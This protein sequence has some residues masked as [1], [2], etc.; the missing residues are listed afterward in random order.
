MAFDFTGAPYLYADLYFKPFSF[1]CGVKIG[2]PEQSDSTMSVS[3]RFYMLDD[4]TWMVVGE[5]GFDK[6]IYRNGSIEAFSKVY[7]DGVV[8]FLPLENGQVNPKSNVSFADG[9]RFKGAYH[10]EKLMTSGRYNGSENIK[11]LWNSKRLSDLKL[12]MIAGEHTTPRGITEQWKSGLPGDYKEYLDNKNAE[13]E[14][15]KYNKFFE[16]MAVAKEAAK[17]QL[18]EEGFDKNDVLTLLDKGEIRIGMPM[19]LIQRANDLKANLVIENDYTVD[20]WKSRQLIILYSTEKKTIVFY[21][22][23]GYNIFGQVSVI[24]L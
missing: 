23:V 21:D 8:N 19:R 4:D 3:N 10:L 2:S 7:E 9:E 24:G 15:E 1:T 6:I 5:N 18:I 12:T 17:K 14:A 11:M 16:N 20:D 22:F 13:I